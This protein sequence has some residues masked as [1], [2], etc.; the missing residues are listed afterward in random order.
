MLFVTSLSFT[1]ERHHKTMTKEL[2]RTKIENRQTR[3]VRLEPK[4]DQIGPIW[5]KSRT[6]S[7][8][9]SVHFASVSQN[10]LKSHMKIKAPLCP[11]WGQSDL[12]LAQICHS[13]DNPSFEF[14]TW[15]G[16]EHGCAMLRVINA[17]FMCYLQ[18]GALRQHSEHNLL[19]QIVWRRAQKL[20]SSA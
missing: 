16:F 17:V 15:R 18:A 14:D 13:W 6:F 1:V 7:D 5:D 12:L 2:T 9:I 11:I 19:T 10:V 3:I 20:T 4:V 8:P